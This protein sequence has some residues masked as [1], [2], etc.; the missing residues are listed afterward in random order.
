MILAFIDFTSGFVDRPAGKL[1]LINTGYCSGVIYCLQARATRP[2]LAHFVHRFDCRA[3]CRG[4]CGYLIEREEISRC[5]QQV[6]QTFMVHRGN[7]L[8]DLSSR[9]PLSVKITVTI[10]R[11]PWLSQLNV[12]GAVKSCFIFFHSFFVACAKL[13]S[14]I[15]TMGSFLRYEAQDQAVGGNEATLN[16]RL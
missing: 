4:G 7:C 11:I 8:V 16:K 14:N 10:C 12:V 13:A 5:S 1:A 15:P 2:G 6:P 3:E 9:L